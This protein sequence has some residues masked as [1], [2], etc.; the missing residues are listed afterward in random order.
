MLKREA[1]VGVRVRKDMGVRMS[2][3]IVPSFNW[4][5]STDGT[6]RTG[7]DFV[8][9]QWDDGTKGWIS[10]VHLAKEAGGGKKRHGAGVLVDFLPYSAGRF[11][12][13]VGGV[14]LRMPSKAHAMRYLA[15]VKLRGREAIEEAG[16]HPLRGRGFDPSHGEVVMRDG[17]WTEEIADL[18]AQVEKA[19]KK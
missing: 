19:L 5:D 12:G 17:R 14:Q 1:K 18:A 10:V 11:A 9:V 7:K 13:G 2:G 16:I 4:K 6:Y 15:A 3:R 8:P